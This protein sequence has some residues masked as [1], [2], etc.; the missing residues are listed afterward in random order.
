MGQTP[1]RLA[2]GSPDRS[3]P[4]GATGL[5]EPCLVAMRILLAAILLAA[6]STVALADAP[7]TVKKMATDDCAKA[8]AQ[9]KTCVI[10]IEGIDLEGGKL[11]PGE[12]AIITRGWDRAGS[13]IHI[14]KDFIPEILKTAEDI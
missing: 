14:R 13:L 12:T 9:N 10:S 6:V 7:A 11:T 3:D 1:F 5:R 4:F 8:R 2:P